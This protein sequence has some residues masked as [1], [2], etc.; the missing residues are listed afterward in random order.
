MKD[1]A[2]QSDLR[3]YP[4]RPFLKEQSIWA[5][6]VYRFG[7]RNDARPAGLRRRLCDRFYWLAFRMIETLTGPRCHVEVVSVELV[8]AV[9]SIQVTFAVCVPVFPYPGLK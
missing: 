4:S 2:F 9:L 5:I 6:W 3:R 7:R 8:G 1:P